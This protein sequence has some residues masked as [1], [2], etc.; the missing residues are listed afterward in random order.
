MRASTW[1]DEVRRAGSEYGHAQW[2]YIN[3]P[4]RP[5]SFPV[6]VALTETNDVVFAI[7]QCENMVSNASTSAK[8]RAAYL[9]LLIHFVGDIHQPLHCTTWMGPEFPTGDKGGNGFYVKPAERGVNLHTMWD[10]LL[11]TRSNPRTDLNEAIRIMKEKPRASLS[12]LAKSKTAKQWALE[13]REIAIE[14]AYL[15]GELKGG[16]S[17]ANAGALPD[18]YTKA[19][20]VVADKQAALAGYRLAVEIERCLK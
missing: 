19:A 12:E 9:A 15:R 14:R 5:P 17:A 3:Y 13:G 11:G 20:K 16:T 7:G 2:H 6:E 18:G 10:G 8:D 1:A 4:L